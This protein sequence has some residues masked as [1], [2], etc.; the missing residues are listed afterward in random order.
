[1]TDSTSWIKRN[2]LDSPDV[3]S[4]ANR[5]ILT[6]AEVRVQKSLEKLSIPEWYLNNSSKPPKILTRN[7][8]ID[9]RPPTWRSPDY[10]NKTSNTSPMVYR[11]FNASQ[12]GRLKMN[13]SYPN[14][15]ATPV[16]KEDKNQTVGVLLETS[17]DRP[18]NISPNISPPKPVTRK[19][20]LNI[21]RTFPKISPSRKI[22]NIN[23]VFPPKKLDLDKKLDD[24]SLLDTSDVLNNSSVRVTNLDNCGQLYKTVMIDEVSLNST[25]YDNDLSYS[26]IDNSQFSNNFSKYLH[27]CPNDSKSQSLLMPIEESNESISPR[28]TPSPTLNETFV[29][30]DKK[31]PALENIVKPKRRNKLVQE[32]IEALKKKTFNSEAEHNAD[33]SREKRES[34]NYS[35]NEEKSPVPVKSYEEKCNPVNSMSPSA[36]ALRQKTINEKKQEYYMKLAYLENLKKMYGVTSTGKVDN[37]VKKVQSNIHD[38]I[39]PPGTSYLCPDTTKK[40]RA[41]RARQNILNANAHLRQ[42]I[43]PKEDDS[44]NS[45]LLQ[46]IIEEFRKK[47]EITQKQKITPGSRNF[48]K[49]LVDVLEQSVDHSYDGSFI[50]SVYHEEDTNNNHDDYQLSDHESEMYHTN[51]TSISLKNSD[52]D[53]Y[54]SSTS[55]DMN[56]SMQANTGAHPVEDEEEVYWIPLPKKPPT[57]INSRN[58]ISPERC[59]S[60]PSKT[61]SPVT[62]S[63][64]L[65]PIRGEYKQGFYNYDSQ[66]HIWTSTQKNKRPKKKSPA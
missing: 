52:S 47:C 54:A 61:K 56:W 24:S 8:P 41:M 60:R 14:P 32:I 34:V 20:K 39:L 43:H 7:C 33:K 26:Y 31:S 16:E 38:R 17:L 62:P 53:V 64:C 42:N 4:K 46:D 27:L 5:R 37:S 25:T 9:L 11:T 12:N 15:K 49:K 58:S 13:S 48:V 6:E 1:M 36:E 44:N 22:E 45:G 23:I 59:S 66:R 55:P 21:S 2:M 3:K 29:I 30:S 35:A 57:R 10:K 51:S 28:V 18:T 19:A 63:P 40:L 50:S 65:S